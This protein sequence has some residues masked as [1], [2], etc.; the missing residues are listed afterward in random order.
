[1]SEHTPLTEA[2]RRA[3]SA[4]VYQNYYM[5]DVFTTVEGIVA[6]RLDRVRDL[7]QAREEDLRALV[8]RTPNDDAGRTSAYADGLE[9]AA[10]ILAAR[11]STATADDGL[12][13]R[14]EALADWCEREEAQL[15]IWYGHDQC[16]S[17]NA[18]MKLRDLLATAALTADTEGAG[19]E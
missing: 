18:A 10:A 14:V 9:E 11:T 1:M 6:G 16:V 3:I 4:V 5:P 7:I 15:V 8:Q 12:R 13:E 19:D 17:H 2:E